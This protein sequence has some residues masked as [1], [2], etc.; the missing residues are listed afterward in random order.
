MCC[1]YQYKYST[2]KTLCWFCD[3]MRSFNCLKKFFLL[4]LIIKLLRKRNLRYCRGTGEEWKIEMMLGDHWYKYI[5]PKSCKFCSK[6]ASVKKDSSTLPK[7][8]HTQTFTHSYLVIERLHCQMCWMWQK[9][10]SLQTVNLSK[11]VYM[12]IKPNI[13]QTFFFIKCCPKEIISLIYITRKRGTRD[14]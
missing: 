10:Q 2:Q 6:I 8:Y 14:L 3:V 4:D 5:E 11:G 12:S 1:F 13:L 7:H 9:Q